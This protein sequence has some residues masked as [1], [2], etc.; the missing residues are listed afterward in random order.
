MDPNSVSPGSIDVRITKR[1]IHIGSAVYP[2]NNIALVRSTRLDPINPHGRRN[3]LI[4][5]LVGGVLALGCCAAGAFG[6]AGGNGGDSAG[7][8]ASGVVL[9]LV[10]GG[11][12]AILGYLIRRARPLVP[13]FNLELVTAG[14]PRA[15][16]T[17]VEFTVIEDLVQLIVRCIED[18]PE[19]EVVRQVPQ[20]LIV[21][22]T[23]D[24][25][26][27]YGDKNV[28]KLA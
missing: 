26:N 8:N 22:L 17:S 16:L 23:G 14:S 5:W 4:G 15:V 10:L 11:Y 12:V 3:R 21:N 24:M 20:Q 6:S 19:I 7:A 27:M 13:I 1:T 2:L 25:I 28:G 18:P 9:L